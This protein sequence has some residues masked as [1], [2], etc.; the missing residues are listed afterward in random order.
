MKSIKVLI[1]VMLSILIL[2][3]G[4]CVP[5][6]DDDI[7]PVDKFIGTWNVSDQATRLNYQVSI[8]ANPLN[9]SEVL[10]SNFADLDH[11]AVGLVV[12][13][14]VVLDNQTMGGNYEVSGSGSYVNDSKLTF[15]YQMNDGIDVESRSAVFTK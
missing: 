15:N 12:G 1:P 2:V 3:F 11:T 4:S 9:S 13:S 5:T 7:N 8:S 6:E 14:T 10:L